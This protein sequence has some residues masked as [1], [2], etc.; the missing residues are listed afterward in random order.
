MV[1][2]NLSINMNQLIPPF[3]S[4]VLLGLM[5]LLMVTRLHRADYLWYLF[6]PN[7]CPQ[8]PTL[9]P[10][11]ISQFHTHEM[12][13]QKHAVQTWCPDTP[14]RNRCTQRRTMLASSYIWSG[15]IWKLKS[16]PQEPDSRTFQQ[17]KSKPINS[18]ALHTHFRNHTEND[19]SKHWKTVI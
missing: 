1:T 4:E 12:D 18:V 9:P 5:S 6:S 3:R 19:I 2:F 10:S 8:K 17:T 13:F 16:L 11:F 15:W 14:A 7:S